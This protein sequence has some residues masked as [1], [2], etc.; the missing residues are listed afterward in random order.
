MANRR[1]QPDPR[2]SPKILGAWLALLAAAG[3]SLAAGHGLHA[4]ERPDLRIDL[5]HWT[6]SDGRPASGHADLDDG[7]LCSACRTRC[8]SKLC[9]DLPTIAGDHSRHSHRP[10]LPASAPRAANRWRD[11]A[12]PPRAPPIA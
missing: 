1:T 7:S 6:A 2:R 12:A 4:H 11:V 5:A 9:V 8:E 3:L 10:L